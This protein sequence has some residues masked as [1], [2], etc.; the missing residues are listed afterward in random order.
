MFFD[1]PLHLGNRRAPLTI[2]RDP[3]TP[4][5]QPVEHP[6]VNLVRQGGPRS[7]ASERKRLDAGVPA[8]YQY[9]KKGVQLLKA[10]HGI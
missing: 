4:P 3:L 1:K 2:T 7:T 5:A 9:S 6:R 8:R 10:D